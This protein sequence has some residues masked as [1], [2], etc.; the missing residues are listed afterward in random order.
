MRDVQLSNGKRAGGPAGSGGDAAGTAN[1]E[2]V[3][4]SRIR[5]MSWEEFCE[6]RN[7]MSTTEYLKLVKR[8]MKVV[9]EDGEMPIGAWGMEEDGTVWL[10]A[11]SENFS[12]YAYR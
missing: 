11:T 7:A 10:E 6:R 8:A 1:R 4:P 3:R 9:A 12:C 2:S 5:W